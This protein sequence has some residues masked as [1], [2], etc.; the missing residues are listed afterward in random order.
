[1]LAAAA[2]VPEDGETGSLVALVPPPRQTMRFL[3]EGEPFVPREPDVV[4]RERYAS[5]TAEASSS[6]A[7]A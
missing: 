2:V 5:F 1:M 7:A 6:T 4:Q 3:P